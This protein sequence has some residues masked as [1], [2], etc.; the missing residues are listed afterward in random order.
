MDAHLSPTV[1]FMP[2]PAVL[3]HNATAQAAA[4]G[5]SLATVPGDF[6][7]AVSSHR[8]YLV[9]FARQR[10]RDPALIDDV[11]QETLLAALQ[12][13][14]RFEHKASLRTW[15]T[16]I[17]L[18]RIADN[19]RHQRRHAGPDS[20]AGAPDAD[21]AALAE[22]DDS[23]A[24]GE[25]IDWLDPQRRLEG[26]QFLAALADG[27][28]ALPPLAARVFALR[29]IDGLSNEEAAQQLGLTPGNSALLLHRA[30]HRLRSALSARQQVPA[31]A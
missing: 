26:R 1:G 17:L 15:L 30:R 3:L 19:V 4:L 25:P 18:R 28:R 21:D 24:A 10:L 11:V 31:F 12:G 27:L 8:P 29:E 16:G 2:H 6:A 20:D 9:R 7:D 13:A 14:D 5:P 22:D 23:T